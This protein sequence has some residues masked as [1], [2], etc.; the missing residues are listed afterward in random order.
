[1][2]LR[3]GQVQ[4]GKWNVGLEHAT[5]WLKT[6]GVWY[7]SHIVHTNC[8]GVELRP[9][10]EFDLT[11]LNLRANDA[12]NV[13]DSQFTLS[14]MKMPDGTGGLDQRFQPWKSLYR[15]GGIVREARPGEGRVPKTVQEMER[16][17]AEESMPWDNQTIPVPKATTPDPRTAAPAGAALPDDA[18]SN[19]LSLLEEY[20][21]ARRDN[22]NSFL[23]ATSDDKRRTALLEAGRLE[24]TFAGRFLEF[25]RE[26]PREP[27]TVDALAAVVTSRFTPP[28][29]QEATDILI[30]DYLKSDTLRPVYRQLATPFAAFSRAGERLLRA[31]AENGP[32]ADDRGQATLSLAYMLLYRGRDLRQLRGA[33]PH[34]LM[35]IEELA[36]SGGRLPAVASDENPDAL[37]QDALKHFDRVA[38]DYSEIKGKNGTLGDAARHELFKLRDLAVGQPAPEIDGTDVDGKSFRLSDERGKIVVVSFAANWC[39]PCRAS[40]PHE[41]RLVERMKGRPFALVSVNIDDD[42]ES[43]RKSLAAGE[44]IWRCWWE[45]GEHR[46]NC[47]RWHV[48]AIPMVYVLDSKGIIRA[49][50]VRGKAIDELV[51]L[52]VN[53][54]ESG[55]NK[56]RP[57]STH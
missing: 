36:R 56:P 25:A 17:K 41:R 6:D 49:K 51:D 28:Q 39:G 18:R 52:L 10:K 24:W 9:V 33:D 21:S 22:E 5:Q 14:A 54:L 55:T 23:Q 35:K 42:K 50:D 13:P 20:E 26:H 11:I 53:E 29:A 38:R 19:Y 31:G 37:S 34:P 7:P 16:L 12:A 46:P 47:Q 27:V 30:R 44:I 48:D 3:V 2:S 40:Y 57:E 8:F 32:T 45:G 4:K 43:L 1:M 15:A